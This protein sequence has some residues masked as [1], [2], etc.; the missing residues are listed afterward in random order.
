MSR[1]VSVEPDVVERFLAEQFPGLGLNAVTNRGGRFPSLRFELGGDLDPW[2][3]WFG[4]EGR[5]FDLPGPLSRRKPRIRQAVDRAAAIFEQVFDRDHA[6]F[7]VAVAWPAEGPKVDELL[8]V[9][10]DESAV[11]SSFGS[12]FWDDPD[13]DPDD[14]YLRLVAACSPR[15]LD[16]R[17]LFRMI[18]HA[19]LGM[20]P[21]ADAVV[22]IINETQ[23]AIFKMYDDRGAMVVGNAES[24]PGTLRTRFADWIIP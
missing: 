2:Y 22:F 1:A 5:I 12:N 18:A 23:P 17:L 20:D 14:H 7:F 6:G 3:R 10:P 11:E 24:D 19:D 9:L 13:P 4:E 15:D 8:A 16:Y 21:S